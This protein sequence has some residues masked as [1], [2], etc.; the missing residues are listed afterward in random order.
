MV[1]LLYAQLYSRSPELFHLA[2]LK[3][4]IHRTAPPTSPSPSNLW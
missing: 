1:V 3:L 2:K 4:Y